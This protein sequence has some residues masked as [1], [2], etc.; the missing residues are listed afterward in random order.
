ML[1][2]DQYDEDWSALWWVRVHG[3]AHEAE[4]RP[5]QLDTLAEAFPA[6]SCVGRRHVGDR[7]P[8]EEVTGWA[9]NPEG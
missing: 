4:R 2:V 8:A 5:V 6:Y 9:A 3:Q 1:L 7:A